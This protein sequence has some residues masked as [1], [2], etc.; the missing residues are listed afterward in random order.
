MKRRVAGLVLLA[1]LGAAPATAPLAAQDPEIPI[2]L[3]DSTARAFQPWLL[4]Y[5]PYVAGGVGRGPVLMA[6]ARYFQPAPWQDRVT[7][8]AEAWVQAGIGLNGSRVA[9]IGVNAPLLADGW[10]LSGRLDA[11]R[12]TRANYFGVGQ[13]TERSDA[14]E[15]A[16]EFAYQ[17]HRT[18]WRA[19][20]DLTRTLM[21]PLAVALGGSY[22]SDRWFALSSTSVFSED[23]G[24]ALKETDA[25]GR[26]ALVLDTRNNEFDPTRGVLVEF[27]GQV[28][29]GGDDYQRLY[30]IARGYHELRQGTVIAARVAASD[31]FGDPALAARFELPGWESRLNVYGGSTN[32]GLDGE[33]RVGTG[34]LFGNLEVRQQLVWIQNTVG[35]TLI[36]FADAGRVFEGEHLRLTT[37][38]LDVSGGGGLVFQLLREALFGVQ[39]AGGPDGARFDISGGWA[40]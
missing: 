3:G 35:I 40:F 37:D 17:V 39:L 26:L 25:S 15:E 9:Q 30:G 36:G 34:V 21:G 23:A 6:R 14:R 29:S 16:D 7:Y 28:G 13:F 1:A 10:R 8:R 32:R 27:G 11:R 4:S 24:D 20:A 2:P 38:D 22:S 18:T 31:M 19:Q 12:N 5:Y 33:R